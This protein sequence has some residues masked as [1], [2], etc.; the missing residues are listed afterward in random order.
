MAAGDAIT[1]TN[2]E[3]FS[4]GSLRAETAQ[5]DSPEAVAT[6]YTK[7]G[8]I[9]WFRIIGSGSDT[10]GQV[11]IYMNSLSESTD[12]DDAGTVTLADELAAG[13]YRY[14]AIGHG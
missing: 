1:V 4:H 7:L 9:I 8:R 3:V 6:F 13:S 14:L 11:T 12:E 10:D 2:R 5:F